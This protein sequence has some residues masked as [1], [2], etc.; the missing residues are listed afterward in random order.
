V[1]DLH[2]H[3]VIITVIREFR[4]HFSTKDFSNILLVSKD[5]AIMVYKV[6]CWL[7]IEFTPMCG[8]RLGY[9]QQNHIDPC[10]VEMASVAMIHLGLDPGKF[11]CFLAGEYTGHH[12]YVCRTQYAVQDYV[13]PD[14]FYHIE[15][16]LLDGCL[17]LLTCEEPLSNK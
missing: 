12:Q 8:P 15:Q 14:N 10:C 2:L 4:V 16:I 1:S 9:K 3:N 6:L 13:T 11:V 7:R 17:A 5:F